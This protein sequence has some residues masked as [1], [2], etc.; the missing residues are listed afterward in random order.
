MKPS[1]DFLD[2]LNDIYFQL[3][4][5]YTR[6]VHALTHRVFALESGW[7]N[8][9]YEK[10][11]S[12]KYRMNH[13]PIPV[14]TVKGFCDIEIGF[15]SLTLSTKLPRQKALEYSFEKVSRFPFEA[16]G[17]EDYLT[18]YKTDGVTMEQMRKKLKESSEK[19]IGF[20]FSLPPDLSENELYEFVKLLRREGFTY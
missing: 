20:S 4:L 17:V 1:S 3:E 2:K 16:Y 12:G 18:D 19:E 14:V 8:G 13:Y 10:D 15:D 9:H 11:K 6:A 5:Q 7:Y